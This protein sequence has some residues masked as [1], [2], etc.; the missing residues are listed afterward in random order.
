M[1]ASVAT[2]CC[3]A[4]ITTLSRSLASNNKIMIV[5]HWYERI[6]I[7]IKQISYLNKEI[8]RL[9][10]FLII[11]KLVFQ[12]YCTYVPTILGVVNVL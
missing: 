8:D 2:Q 10:K 5:L 3:N 11:Y 12:V 9:I 6:V 7:I 1:I 4:V